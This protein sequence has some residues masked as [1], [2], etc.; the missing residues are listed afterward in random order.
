MTRLRIAVEKRKI[1]G[2][3]V[4]KLR[5]EGIL[6][7]NIYGKDIK[8]TAVQLPEKEFQK[9]YKEVGET[10]LLDLDV[11]KQTIP[12]LIH[13]V[14]SDYKGILLHADFYKVNL[15]EKI[16][17]MIPLVLTG[18]PKA[19]R[20]K[21][22]LLMQIVSEIEVEALPENLPEKIE[23]DV[24]PLSS[25]DEQITAGDIKPPKDVTILTDSSQVIA[26]ISE[27]VT[28]EAQEQAVEE[29]E[30]AQ[31][32]KAESAE[33]IPGEEEKPSAEKAEAKEKKEEE[34]KPQEKPSEE[35]T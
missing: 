12:V 6:P 24:E 21:V 32:A 2:K 22:G 7:A 35:K 33:E 17:T 16:K 5:R 30:K 28:K 29:A 1:L 18:E 4:K 27:L 25:V 3:K 14:Q 13:N 23:I 31:E 11:D 26:K 9:I 8:S 15:K 34:G 10:G 20:D 19:A